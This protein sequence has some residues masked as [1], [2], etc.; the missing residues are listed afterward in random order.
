M[1]HDD[2][3][4][5]DELKREHNRANNRRPALRLPLHSPHLEEEPAEASEEDDEP[6]RRGVRVLDMRNGYSVVD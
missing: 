1:F 4:L 6:S 2:D 5:Y 3:I